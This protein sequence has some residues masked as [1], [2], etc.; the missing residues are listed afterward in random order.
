M[1]WQGGK[2]AFGGARTYPW[3]SLTLGREDLCV[4]LVLVIEGVGVGR[5]HDGWIRLRD[6]I[7]LSE[8]L[9]AIPMELGCY[10]SI[11]SVVVWF[12]VVCSQSKS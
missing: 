4:E 6:R 12:R 11:G 2:N 3:A 10:L 9:M 8:C 1:L 5:G 7:E